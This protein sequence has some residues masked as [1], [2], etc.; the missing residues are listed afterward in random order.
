MN[1]GPVFDKLDLA[2]WPLGNSYT[3]Y[4]TWMNEGKNPTQGDT[5]SN[6]H[7]FWEILRLRSEV[8]K[9][10]KTRNTLQISLLLCL[11]QRWLEIVLIFTQARF[12][13]IS[14]TAQHCTSL[15]YTKIEFL[16]ILAPQYI[17]TFFYA[18]LCFYF[19]LHNLAEKWPPKKCLGARSRKTDCLT[20]FSFSCASIF[21]S[22]C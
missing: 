22:S 5:S 12:L 19:S 18:V 17:S 14:F 16:T 9:L 3:T 7:T 6:L 10:E 13:R 8:L 15:H 11:K 4:I 1:H 2:Y 21:G 20:E